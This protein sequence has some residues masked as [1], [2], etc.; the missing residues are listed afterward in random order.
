MDIFRHVIMKL[1]CIHCGQSFEGENIRFCSQ[2][3]RDSYIVSIDKRTREAV[4]DD[5]SHTTNLS[6]Y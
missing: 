2:G 6:R 5:P 4:R 1:V 3:C